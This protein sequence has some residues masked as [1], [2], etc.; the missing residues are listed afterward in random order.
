MAS[1]RSLTFTVAMFALAGCANDPPYQACSPDAPCAAETRLCLSNTASTG[2]TVRFC[3]KR[4][5]TP[6]PTSSECP[7][8][9]ACIR[10]NGGDPVCIPRCTTT[11]ECPFANALCTTLGESLGA[12]VCSVAP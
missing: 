5:N 2:R 8:S 1:A 10:L 7:G 12:R 4:C 9:A 11:A 6:A 3:S